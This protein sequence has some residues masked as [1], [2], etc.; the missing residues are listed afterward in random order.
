MNAPE[1]FLNRSDVMR[2]VSTL[3]RGGVI[4]YP[5]DTIWGIGCDARASSAIKQIFEL[6]NRPDSKAFI[7]LVD[8]IE[9]LAEY[10][11][12]LPENLAEEFNSTDRAL[13]FVLDGAKGL[14]E[15]LIAE[16]GSIG[17]RITRDEFCLALIQGIDGPI[18]STSANIS[19][20][21][22]SGY[23]TDIDSSIIKGVN[24]V[25]QQKQNEISLSPPSRII[26]LGIDGTR[27]VL[28]D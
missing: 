15:N 11:S 19:G 9:R 2:S 5:S 1:E 14:P 24:Y 16:D 22:F 7:I 4:L 21:P 13:T 6:K 17:I 3:K 12:V 18:V 20:E 10:V 26:R 8:S 28:R 27:T 23:Y 25:V